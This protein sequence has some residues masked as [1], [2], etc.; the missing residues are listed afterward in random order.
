MDPEA[1][2]RTKLQLCNHVAATIK[3]VRPAAR[4]LASPPPTL[5]SP[6]K[7]H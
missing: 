5:V 3:E 6:S 4:S 1:E 7:F 2:E